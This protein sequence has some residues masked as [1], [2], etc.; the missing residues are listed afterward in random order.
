MT[1][2]S[3]Y[4]FQTVTRV[5][6]GVERI[7]FVNIESTLKSIANEFYSELYKMGYYVSQSICR[8]NGISIYLNVKNEAGDCVKVRIS[9]HSIGCPNRMLN[10]VHNP[11][12]VEEIVSKF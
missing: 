9:D 12:T 8:S 6:G 1:T 2:N 7:G 11:E 4:N 5:I 3:K 10:E